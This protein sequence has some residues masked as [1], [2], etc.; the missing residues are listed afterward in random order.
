M[1]D[2]NT[3]L[4]VLGVPRTPEIIASPKEDLATKLGR[5]FAREYPGL[6]KYNT[7]FLYSGDAKDW[8]GVPTA[9]RKL[10]FYP[11]G[12]SDSFN[13]AVPAVE[14]FDKSMGPKAVMGEL[15]SHYLPKVDPNFAAV[16]GKFLQSLTPSQKENMLRPDYEESQRRA[17]GLNPEERSFMLNGDSQ[18]FDQWL[19][20]TGGDAYFRGYSTGQYPAD[21]YTPEQK[22]MLDGLMQTITGKGPVR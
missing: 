5:D 13:K 6:S 3:A 17:E 16:R 12:E 22:Q 20:S 8:R 14:I 19:N 1:A 21:S 2:V 18:S 7:A 10:E 4:N 11:P 15:F 9:G